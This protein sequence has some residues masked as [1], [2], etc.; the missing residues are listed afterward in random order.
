MGLLKKSP[1]PSC[2]SCSAF[3]Y[4]GLVGDHTA[5]RGLCLAHPT[6]I[7]K[8]TSDWCREYEVEKNPEPEIAADAGE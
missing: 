8:Q 6:P 7:Q 1:E 2:A 5:G 4:M 3:H